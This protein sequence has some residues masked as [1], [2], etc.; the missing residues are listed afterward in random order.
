M[1]LQPVK[2]FVAGIVFTATPAFAAPQW[3]EDACWYFHRLEQQ[4]GKALSHPRQGRGR[5]DL[6]VSIRGGS[7]SNNQGQCLSTIWRISSL[8]TSISSA[9]SMKRLISLSSSADGSWISAM[10]VQQHQGL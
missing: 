8:A 5:P 3:V 4:A 2:I 9:S 6:Q 10:P 1:N 7:F